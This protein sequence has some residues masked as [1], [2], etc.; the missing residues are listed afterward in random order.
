MAVGVRCTP[1]HGK[2]TA[3]SP[4][5]IQF[6]PPSLPF[7]IHAWWPQY[8][9]WHPCLVPLVALSLLPLSLLPLSLMPLSLV[10]LYKVRLLLLEPLV[11]ASR[12]AAGTW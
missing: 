11:L 1:V 8:L 2:G 6:L 9:W 7:C 12:L 5:C 10:P 3:A 4:R